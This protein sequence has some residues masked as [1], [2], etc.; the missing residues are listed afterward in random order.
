MTAPDNRTWEVYQE[1]NDTWTVVFPGR[2]ARVTGFETSRDAHEW[3][4][5]YLLDYLVS[6]TRLTAEL[7][8][9]ALDREAKRKGIMALV[10]E[11]PAK[12][13]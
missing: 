1:A 4:R 3:V 7:K 6:H 2:A 8:Q 12:S 13:H 5:E 10:L 11:D 9:D